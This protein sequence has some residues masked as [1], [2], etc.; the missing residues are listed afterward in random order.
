M[1]ASPAFHILIDRFCLWRAAVL[2][3]C[4]AALGVWL[5][6][7]VSMQQE[8]DTTMTA[9]TMIVGFVP[10]VVAA[11]LAHRRPVSLRWDTQSW[12]FGPA[13]SYGDEPWA[14]R[15]HVA[16]D[17]DSWMLLKFEHEVTGRYRRVDWIP[18]Q[19]LGMESSW[20]A[21]R[22]AVYSSR[23]S[24]SLDASSARRDTPQPKE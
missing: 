24:P 15:L 13:D 18:V 12:R 10:I 14:G 19:R 9:A 21:L 6:W 20:H 11:K 23:P 2:A 1:R 7:I 22:C 3:A 16:I 4:V 5:A 8:F 17:L